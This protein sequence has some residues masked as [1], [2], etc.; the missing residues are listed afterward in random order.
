MGDSVYVKSSSFI[1]KNRELLFDIC[2]CSMIP[3]TPAASLRGEESINI[4]ATFQAKRAVCRRGHLKARQLG[5]NGAKKA[6]LQRR[7][8]ASSSDQTQV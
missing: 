8:N 7:L 2:D 1:G 6:H 3:H 4:H 5:C